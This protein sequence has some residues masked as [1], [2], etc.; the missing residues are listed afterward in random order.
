[1]W[2]F[3]YNKQNK[4]SSQVEQPVHIDPLVYKC[5]YAYNTNMPPQ[6]C[7]KNV[8]FYGCQYLIFDF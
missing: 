8:F 7:P 1:M 3:T 5:K 6:N 2:Q 4:R